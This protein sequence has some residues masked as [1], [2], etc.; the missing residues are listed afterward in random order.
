MDFLEKIGKCA[1]VMYEIF[2]I[3]NKEE[4]TPE[5]KARS[6][7]L[8]RESLVHLS[9]LHRHKHIEVS[10]N[11]VIA[12]LV[13]FC[14]RATTESNTDIQPTVTPLVETRPP[15]QPVLPYESK[16][17]YID[18]TLYF[19]DRECSLY[20]KYCA[21]VLD[22]TTEDDL[23]ELNRVYLKMAAFLDDSD[24]AKHLENIE[25]LKTPQ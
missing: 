9:E 25:L 20:H 4:Q 24:Y 16:Y 7:S 6:E 12:A 8:L 1:S 15:V 14:G 3:D 22:C 2:A 19:P 13:K 18:H 17:S 21:R 23:T 5:D 11:D 10:S